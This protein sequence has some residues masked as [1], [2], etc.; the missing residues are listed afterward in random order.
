VRFRPLR[1]ATSRERVRTLIAG[2][3]L[4]LV[5]LIAV[6][7]VVREGSAVGIG[8]VVVAVSFLISVPS[9]MLVRRRAVRESREA[10][11]SV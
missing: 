1:P 8:L 7:I 6:A 4:W 3:I 5:A 10:P 9:L 2:P 11:P